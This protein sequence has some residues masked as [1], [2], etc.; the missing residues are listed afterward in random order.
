MTEPQRGVDEHG[1]DYR[2]SL[3]NE[4]TFLA[5]IRTSLALVAAGVG[6]IGVASH[7]STVTGRRILG[8]CLILLG[9]T[10]ASLSYFRWRRTQE[11]MR[12][13]GTLPG[14]R[15]LL[16]LGAGLAIA[17]VFAFALVVEQAV[18]A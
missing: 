13:G 18:K 15:T 3:A 1:L 14:A 10:S 5:W 11:A 4:R 17:A 7:F 12:V 6:V 9:A 2:F 8:I 16:V